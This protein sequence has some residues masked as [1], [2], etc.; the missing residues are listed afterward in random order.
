MVYK[1]E[2]SELRGQI[3]SLDNEI[4]DKIFKLSKVT[5]SFKQK[6]KNGKSYSSLV[7]LDVARLARDKNLDEEAV[8]RIFKEIMEL[9][10]EQKANLK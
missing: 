9:I 2:L 8:L 3:D 6:I 1:T 5:K 7:S 10:N 4:I